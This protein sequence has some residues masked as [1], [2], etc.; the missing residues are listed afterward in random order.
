MRKY[1]QPFF[2]GRL[3]AWA[4][5]NN[6]PPWHT[7]GLQP[8]AEVAAPV[9]AQATPELPDSQK[10]ALLCLR[11]ARNSNAF[12]CAELLKRQGVTVSGR[13]YFELAK[14]GLARQATTGFHIITDL[15]M[16][17]SSRIA[18]EIARDNGLHHITRGGDHKT[19][20]ARCTCQWSASAPKSGNGA[21]SL[22]GHV[23][24]HLAAVKA[25]VHRAPRPTEQIVAE[26]VS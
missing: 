9:I 22:D 2:T 8:L 19:L 17:R 6:P 16:H 7:E 26:M 10:L 24:K 15:G 25:G 11:A 1:S 13:D 18:R 23:A 21:T 4:T 3:P 5:L 12:E 20:S 14:Q